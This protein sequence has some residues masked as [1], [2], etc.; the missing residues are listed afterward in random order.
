MK[1]E[2]AQYQALDP[3]PLAGS[4]RP[5]HETDQVCQ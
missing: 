4:S 5:E 3:Q 2:I 1:Q